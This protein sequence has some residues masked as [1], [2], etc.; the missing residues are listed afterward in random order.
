MKVMDRERQR[1]TEEREIGENE[2]KERDDR[3]K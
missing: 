2:A 3:E 1:N